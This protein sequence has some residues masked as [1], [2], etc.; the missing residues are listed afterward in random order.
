MPAKQVKIKTQPSSNPNYLAL[1]TWV[2]GHILDFK[3]GWKLSSEPVK[4]R[5]TMNE[6]NKV[7]NLLEYSSMYKT[8]LYWHLFLGRE[9]MMWKASQ[10]DLGSNVSFVF[11]VK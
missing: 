1:D 10:R 6:E 11:P 3:D 5:T 2:D 8:H 9:S 4:K 7:K